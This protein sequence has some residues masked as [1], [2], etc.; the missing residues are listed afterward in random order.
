MPDTP[1]IYDIE[2]AGRQSLTLRWT[3]RWM[4]EDPPVVWEIENRN[5]PLLNVPSDLFYGVFDN[6]YALSPTAPVFR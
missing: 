4:T 2:L 1:P 3:A 6:V 5:F